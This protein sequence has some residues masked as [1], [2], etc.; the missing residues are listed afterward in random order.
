[1]SRIF[2]RQRRGA[3][4]SDY[5]H[6]SAPVP[7]QRRLPING[8]RILYASGQANLA[9]PGVGRAPMRANVGSR[10]VL[11]D[12]AQLVSAEGRLVVLEPEMFDGVAHVQGDF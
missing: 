1:M 7:G 4:A 8:L 6:R 9:A 11:A 12:G 10:E 3:G 5:C 2:K